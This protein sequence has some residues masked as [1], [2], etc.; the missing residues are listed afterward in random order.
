[1]HPVVRTLRA[2][3]ADDLPNRPFGPTPAT[4]RTLREAAALSFPDHLDHWR[5][6]GAEAW[7][8]L[9]AAPDTGSASAPPAPATVPGYLVD[10]YAFRAFMLDTCSVGIADRFTR[11]FPPQAESWE[12]TTRTR[13]RGAPS[14]GIAPVRLDD[15]VHDTPMLRG[16]L[17]SWRDYLSGLGV[18]YPPDVFRPPQGRSWRELYRGSVLYPFYPPAIL[19][20]SFVERVNAPQ[21]EELLSR[22]GAS[23][24]MSFYVF[25]LEAHEDTHRFQHGEPMLCEYLLAMLW[26]RFLD[27]RELWLWERDRETGV[28]FNLEEP[29]L[30]RVPLSDEFHAG[31]VRDTAAG[32]HAAFGP[33]AY[34]QLCTAAWLFDARAL[35]YRE[36]LQLVTRRLCGE[37]VTAELAGMLEQLEHRLADQNTSAPFSATTEQTREVSST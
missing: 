24:I 9:S 31:L 14:A 6:R 10:R 32:S 5:A 33:G 20:P 28:S 23:G 17:T 16:F 18:E 12:E 37:D 13:L 3:R 25:L 11:P 35:A 21:R 36:Y 30:R 26:C 1:M 19:G 29:Y 34:H 27:E 4:R 7:Q 15:P 22:Y 2:R 8:A